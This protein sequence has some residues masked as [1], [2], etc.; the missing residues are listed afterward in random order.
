VL[1][2]K[3]ERCEKPAIVF[4]PYGSHSF[5]AEHFVYFFEKRVK[6]NIRV[7]SLLKHAE[8]IAVAYSG[9]KD[10]TAT[11]FMLNQIFSK[12]NKLSAIIIDEGIPGY[13]DKAVKIAVKN[14]ESWNIP[15]NLVSLEE[16]LGFRMIDVMKKLKSSDETLGS[17]CSYCGVLR[18]QLLNK[19][20]LEI[21][22]DKLATGHNLDDECQSIAMNFFDNKLDQF[23][24]LGSE[25]RN[26]SI[27]FVPRIKPLYNTP[28]SEIKQYVKIKNIPHF[29]K[30]ACP[31]R[32]EA[33]RSFYRKMIDSAE[34][35]FPGT[36]YSILRFFQQS[37]PLLEKA[38][39]QKK[40][41]ACEKCGFPSS[42]KICGS[43][44]QISKLQS[45]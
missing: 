13:R 45:L 31:L 19:K 34:E 39:K 44:R 37:K 23:V 43:C 36:K 35:E 16:E 9:G 15:F 24:R 38:F 2:K 27:N 17:S 1:S 41:R 22:A 25:V 29:S 32:H 40:L 28:E 33:K 11:L 18:R 26:D 10:S 7:N 6:K 21:K 12:S 14:C 30:K 3:C 5:C 8:H 42:Q 4:L 20:A